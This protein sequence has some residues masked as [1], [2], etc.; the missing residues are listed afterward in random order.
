MGYQNI[1]F[2]TEVQHT[3]SSSPFSTC[4]LDVFFTSKREPRTQLEAEWTRFETQWTDFVQSGSQL[5][6][7]SL[8]CHPT[9]APFPSALKLKQSAPASNTPSVLT[10]LLI[11]EIHIHLDEAQA[12]PRFDPTWLQICGGPTRCRFGYQIKAI[13]IEETQVIQ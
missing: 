11:G 4:D 10:G 5:T 8:C 13:P 9:H 3:Q 12:S 2:Q 6:D 1:V 7:R